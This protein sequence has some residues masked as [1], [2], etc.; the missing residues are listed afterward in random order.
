MNSSYKQ[1][2]WRAFVPTKA[3]QTLLAL[4]M[5]ATLVTTSP[6]VVNTIG[7]EIPSVVNP[8]GE[9]IAGGAAGGIVM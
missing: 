3:I 1:T 6:P 8:R 2:L 5:L 4:V 7:E 9:K